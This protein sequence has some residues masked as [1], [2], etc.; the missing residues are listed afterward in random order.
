MAWGTAQTRASSKGLAGLLVFLFG[1]WLNVYPEW[2][3]HVWKRE[4]C[5][6]GRLYMGGLFSLARHI[7]YTGEIL[8]FVG[9]S[10]VTGALW[11]MWVPAVMGLGMCTLS[12]REIEFYLSQRY[13]EDWAV[14]IQQVP[15]LMI[16][17]LF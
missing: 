14:Y 9:F 3:R 7:N 11:T 13:K 1:T 4:A 15:W 5:H 12:I 6:Q 16:P 10:L 17:G 2:Q 8:S